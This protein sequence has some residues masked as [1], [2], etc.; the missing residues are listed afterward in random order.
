MGNLHTWWPAFSDTAYGWRWFLLRPVNTDFTR[1]GRMGAY[2]ICKQHHGGEVSNE[3]FQ[4]H[5]AC[6]GPSTYRQ[7]SR[8]GHRAHRLARL[9]VIDRDGRSNR[10]HH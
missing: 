7:H 4:G 5:F 6:Q 10:G 1:S 8:H 2:I 3:G 9:R